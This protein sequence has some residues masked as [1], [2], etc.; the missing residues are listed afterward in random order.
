MSELDHLAPA[1]KKRGPKRAA[2]TRRQLVA[3][4][5]GRIGLPSLAVL[6]ATAGVAFA[7]GGPGTSNLEAQPAAVQSVSRDFA[8]RPDRGGERTPSESAAPTA[9][10]TAD[11]TTDQEAAAEDQKAKEQQGPV[12]MSAQPAETTASKSAAPSPSKTSASAQTQ[13][14]A[15]G[16]TWYATETVNVRSGASASSDQLGSLNKGDAVKGTGKTSNGFTEVTYNG[17]SGWVSSEFLSKDKPAADTSSSAKADT[18]K[19]APAPQTN[20]GSSNSS[21]SAGSSS[22]GGGSV[23]QST[24]CGSLPG[25]QPNAVKVHQALCAQFPAISSYGGVREADGGYH[26]SGR[27]IDAMVS[28]QALGQAVANYVRANAGSLGVTEVIWNQQIWTTQRSSEGWRAMADRGSATA[29]HMDHVHV[30]VS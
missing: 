13:Q 3:K 8:S 14:A 12:E 22:S 2:L 28:N 4:Y 24:S 18:S 27:A 1:P 25:L 6:A 21:Q 30:S 9:D 16:T 5:A 11:Q 10:P 17:K 26:S 23:P 20:S 19:A 29:N 15:S 7:I